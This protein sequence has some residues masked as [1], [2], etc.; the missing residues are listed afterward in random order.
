V[1]KDL[2]F[3]TQYGQAKNTADD[4]R[5]FAEE[6]NVAMARLVVAQLES[7]GHEAKKAARDMRRMVA[8]LNQNLAHTEGPFAVMR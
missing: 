5:K 3:E 6:I 1:L 4:I 7:A 2:E 8:S